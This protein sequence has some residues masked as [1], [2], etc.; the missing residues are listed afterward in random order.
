MTT[1]PEIAL[2]TSD[3]PYNPL[4][5]YDSW[6]AYDH[7]KGYNT[8][9]YLARIVRTT[10]EFGDSNYTNDIERAID[11]IVILNLISWTHPDISYIKVVGPEP[12]GLDDDEEDSDE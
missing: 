2:S 6:E 3:N 1:N 8:S 7:Q 9:E 4:T 5:D 10:N 11:E 12:E